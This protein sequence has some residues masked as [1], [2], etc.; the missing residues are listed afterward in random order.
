MGYDCEAAIEFTVNG[1]A[2]QKLDVAGKAM[3]EKT[4]DELRNKEI[5]VKNKYI[6]TTFFGSINFDSSQFREL[7]GNS[8]QD[9]KLGKFSGFKG[10]YKL[11][12]YIFKYDIYLADPT[13][14][15]E[16][17]IL[18]FY[19][20]K[21]LPESTIK[22]GIGDT[23]YY[24]SDLELLNGEIVK[25]IGEACDE[26]GEV[27]W[28]FRSNEMEMNELFLGLNYHWILSQNNDFAV[29]NAYFQR[30]YKDIVSLLFNDA[31]IGLLLWKDEA[32]IQS[33]FEQTDISLREN[34]EWMLKLINMK[35]VFYSFAPDS[36]KSDRAFAID[37]LNENVYVFQ[38]FKKEFRADKE[39]VMLLLRLDEY[40]ELVEHIEKQ[41]LE[42]PEVMEL[43]LETNIGSFPQAD[44]AF[45]KNKDIVLK[46]ISSD[47]TMLQYAFELSADAEFMKTAL[48]VQPLSYSYMDYR[49]KDNIELATIALKKDARVF[50][51]LKKTMKSNRVLMTAVAKENPDILPYLPAE[52]KRDKGFLMEIL[53]EGNYVIFENGDYLS[54]W[55][56]KNLDTN[57]FKSGDELMPCNDVNIWNENENKNK[58]LYS[59]YEFNPEL[60]DQFGKIYCWMAV[61][62]KDEAVFYTNEGDEFVT[63]R[64]LAPKGWRVPFKKDWENLF[65]Y[66]LN[67]SPESGD[68]AT[69]L[70]K[71][72]SENWG[73]TN[74]TGFS[75]LPGGKLNFY[76]EN[77]FDGI[78]KMTRFWCMD[79]EIVEPDDSEP[80]IEKAWSVS[81]G[82][83]VSYDLIS[84]YE[85]AYVRL[86]LNL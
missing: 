80:Y 36:M 68:L 70:G 5:P 6:D 75:L 29:A 74:E 19:V 51:Y 86:V 4:L 1:T 50:E 39:I 49:L 3:L 18:S 45:R 83:T 8:E 58:P 41:A 33:L 12:Q 65:K 20:S 27:T 9:P 56:T 11:E 46:V 30:R 77:A 26:E 15:L 42:D 21:Q 44:P 23:A 53:G 48:E 40:G 47:F 22:L 67:L 35:N 71:L 79:H 55:M 61:Y 17:F 16:L 85:G 25:V 2:S 84:I 10:S 38:Y 60:G 59:T 54:V 62:P 52:L 37:A 43:F 34:R 28:G 7:E 57:V 76:A 63:P 24:W 73:G 64:S 31:N 32:E 69:A 14:A 66:V 82:E 72:K 81:I 78:H 13:E